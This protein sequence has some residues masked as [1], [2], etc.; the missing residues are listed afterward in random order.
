MAE[1]GKV[2]KEEKSLKWCSEQR[3]GLEGLSL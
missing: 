2:E 3:V 1:T